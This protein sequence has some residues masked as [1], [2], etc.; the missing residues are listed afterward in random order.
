M[1]SSAYGDVYFDTRKQCEKYLKKLCLE[2][3]NIY[4]QITIVLDP[5]KYGVK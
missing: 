5:A 2:Y 4:F 1:I 3:P